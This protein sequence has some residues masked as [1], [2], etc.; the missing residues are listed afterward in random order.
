MMSK[1]SKLIKTSKMTSKMTKISKMMV[2]LGWLGQAGQVKLVRSGCLVENM[3][4]EREN[5]ERTEELLGAWLD[6]VSNVLRN[7]I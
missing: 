6:Q 5:S 2:R 1:M 4:K 7:N 3:K